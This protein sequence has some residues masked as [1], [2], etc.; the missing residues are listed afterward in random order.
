MTVRRSS[1]DAGATRAL[2]VV[3]PL[4]LLGCAAA[5]AAP[6]VP[7]AEPAHG[8]AGDPSA[9]RPQPRPPVLTGS[10]EDAERAAASNGDGPTRGQHV[11]VLANGRYLA[12]CGVPA[13]AQVD[14]CAAVRAGR[15]EGLTVRLL[16]P[17]EA[18]ERCVGAA[19]R[20]LSYPS[21]PGLDVTRV[22]FAAP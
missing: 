9:R 17:D 1:T 5:P 8:A 12:A 10:C 11:A 7:E 2:L 19:I 6:V 14:V 18:L 15:V 13:E 3:L 16:P 20:A 21:K 22:S 4:R